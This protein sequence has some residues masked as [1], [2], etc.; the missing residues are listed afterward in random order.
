MSERREG[1]VEHIRFRNADNGYTVFDLA[2]V[3]GTTVCVGNLPAI[4]EGEYL[5]AE[6]ETILHP[7][8]GPQFQ[9][10]QSQVKVP[11]DGI[12]LQR[13]LGSGAI[14]GIGETLAR[15]IVERFR[16]DTLRIVE[17]EPER[18]AEI[19]GISERKA[20]EIGEQFAA[21]SQTQS[22]LIFLSQYGISLALA[23]KIHNK[24]QDDIYR[25]LKENP[26]QLAEDIQGVGFRTADEIARQV[27]VRP[28]SEF[29]I[30]AGILYCLGQAGAAGH[31]FLPREELL[32]RATELLGVE[33]EDMDRH[34]MDL[35]IDRKIIARTITDEEGWSRDVVYTSQAYHLE[36]HT[37]RMLCDLN[38]SVGGDL[39]AIERQIARIEAADAIEL[40]ALQHRAVVQAATNG[41]SVLTGGPGTGKTTTINTMIRYFA[42]TGAEIA[43]AAP[44]GRAAKRM[45]ETTGYAASTIHR[46][47]ELSGL[48]EEDGSNIRFERNGD[49]PLE[50]DVII[51]DEM[52]MVDVYLLH[53][54]LSAVVPGTRL[55][56][57]GDEDQLPSVGPGSVLRDMILSECFPVVRLTQIFRQAQESDIIVNAHR[58][59]A[60][61][62]VTLDNKS[63]DFFFLARDSAPVI[64]RIVLSLVAEKLPP[65]VQAEQMDVQVL[66]PMRKGE[67]GVERLNVILQQYLNPPAADKEEKETA[68]GVFRVGDKVMQIRNDYQ[69]EWEIRG[70][71]G[72]VGQ[73]GLGVFNG[74]MGVIRAIDSFLETVTVAFEEGKEVT[75]PFKQLDELELAYATTIHKAQGSEYPAVVIP[76]LA[77]PRMLMTRNLL[78]TAV[79]RARKC[80][81]L[82]GDPAVFQA[83]IDNQFEARRY[84]TLAAR[85]RE[86]SGVL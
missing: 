1:Y 35:A 37:A 62:Q 75:Y 24:Y 6:G 57:V 33:A 63:R 84:T 16:G 11:T 46:L 49:N 32:Q 79:T 59:N 4:H 42:S 68:Q 39:S 25:L 9:V 10:R 30:R 19:K 55:I 86:L 27:G 14:K 81:V 50:A 3:D 76:L 70:K 41:L 58:I 12:A 48:V 83:M 44:T 15:R 72:I 77:G 54:L 43:L 38:I 18:L 53:A 73:R 20:R 23:I 34:L 64:Q 74:D 78:Y 67:L 80:V 40:D 60:G 56:F 5:A 85:I 61:R 21:S 52:S 66:A 28:D 51:I 65:Y 45:T 29:R 47:L 13:Y 22:A 69:L 31:M 82:V 8:Y 71:H 2:E 7:V 36:L 17:E 26:Y